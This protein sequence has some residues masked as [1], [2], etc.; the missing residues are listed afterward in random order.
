MKIE[1]INLLGKE[2]G[3]KELQLFINKLS[4]KPET[5]RFMAD[6]SGEETIIIRQAGLQIAFDRSRKVS[7]IFLFSGLTENYQEYPLPL[8]WSLA[9]R[10]SR[11]GARKLL[12]PPSLSGGP[13][14][15]LSGK[16]VFFWD[17]WDQTKYSLH[18]RYTEDLGSITQFT[19]MR[20]DRVP[21]RDISGQ[22][23]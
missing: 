2:I 11:E 9:F 13:V 15:D 18:L 12:G 22:K 1:L 20:P 19:L 23:T 14:E 17:R 21:R 5:Y 7:V 3:D 16:G 10:T 8:P 6:G 4:G